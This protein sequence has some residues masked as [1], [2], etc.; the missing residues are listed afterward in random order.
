MGVLK[1]TH[2]SLDLAVD[3]PLEPPRELATERTDDLT[4]EPGVPGLAE[5]VQ[6]SAAP[7]KHAPDALKGEL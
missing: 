4:R 7:V 1:P 5:P 2:E 6:P 3:Q